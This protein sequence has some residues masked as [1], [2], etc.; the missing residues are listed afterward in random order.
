MSPAI[1]PFSEWLWYLSIRR[2]FSWSDQLPESELLRRTR[3]ISA[4]VALLLGRP[5]E[6]F[7]AMGQGLAETVYCRSHNLTALDRLAPQARRRW[8]EFRA[9]AGKIP[10]A[11]FVSAHLGPFQ[12]QMDLLAPLPQPILFL[13]RS[14]RWS[15]L[16]VT[17]SR[18]RLESDRFRYADVNRPRELA[19]AMSDGSSIAFLAD[20]TATRSDTD[21]GPRKFRVRPKVF[22]RVR[23]NDLPVR[24]ASRLAVPL[25]VGG[26][27]NLPAAGH[28]FRFGFEFYRIDP[29]SSEQMMDGFVDGLEG[30][31][32]RNLADWIWVERR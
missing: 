30:T 19:A 31:I 21:A 32:R 6:P 11:V 13:Y 18:L 2:L 5:R 26:L 17:L 10:R 28:E 12:M 23:V 4:A 16:A 15:P 27:Y 8:E 14:Y 29:A 22:G 7:V 25:F 24:I 3:R 9:S 20:G 1:P